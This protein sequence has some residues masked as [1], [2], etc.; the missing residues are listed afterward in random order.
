[1][2]CFTSFAL[3]DVSSFGFFPPSFFFAG[4]GVFAGSFGGSFNDFTLP[5]VDSLLVELV[6]GFLFAFLWSFGDFFWRLSFRFGRFFS[7]RFFCFGVVE[8]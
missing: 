6:D 3:K 8:L 7:L 5:G 1:V 2:N 4:V